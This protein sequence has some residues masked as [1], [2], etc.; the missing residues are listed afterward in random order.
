MIPGIEVFPSPGSV[1][2]FLKSKFY[3][4]G[5]SVSLDGNQAAIAGI[6]LSEASFRQKI[7]NRVLRWGL[8]VF[9]AGYLQ[10]LRLAEWAGPNKKTIP[11]TG[12]EILLTGTFYS[13]NWVEAHVRPLAASS[14]CAKIKLISIHPI[15][16][17][18]KVEVLE[19][20][21]W[22]VRTFG[23]PTARLILFF[24]VGIRTRPHLVGGFHLLFNG[25]ASA[26]L[27]GITGARSIYFC[28]GGPAE[29]LGGGINSEN[30]IFEKLTAPHKK[31]ETYLIEVVKR[32]DLIITMGRGAADFFNRRGVKSPIAVASGGLDTNKNYPSKDPP[33]YDLILIGRIAP[34]KRIDLFLA[35][36]KKIKESMPEITAVIVGEGSERLLLEEMAGEWG[37]RENV[38]FVGFQSDPENWLRQAKVFV[39][40]SETEGLSLALMEAM[41]CGLPAVVPDV[42]DLKELV[43]NT[44][45]GYLVEDRDPVTYASFILELLKNP[46]RLEMFS[47]AA[48]RS[49]DRYR[50]E[51]AIRLWDGILLEM[52]Q[53]RP[54]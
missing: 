49:A 39:L 48:S 29:V 32:L 6:A 3:N 21:S 5:I 10:M 40:T 26:F 36:I 25:L 16:R 14:K 53:G 37:L 52:D 45:N 12:A 4:S 7:T 2:N 35:V 17:I 38:D 23:G 15:L 42:G 1:L 8:P 51:E 28:V 44:V 30:R 43:A 19:P 27:A 24:I 47:K 9:L 20:P 54:D 33:K 18:D 13:Q 41:L 22:L 50:L 46:A 34:I 11:A 31:V